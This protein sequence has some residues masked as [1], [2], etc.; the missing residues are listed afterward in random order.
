MQPA[1]E[2]IPL[3]NL[4]SSEWSIR[5][6]F[7]SNEQ[8][9]D[10]VNN[11]PSQTELPRFV[12]SRLSHDFGNCLPKYSCTRHITNTHS[13]TRL[14]KRN[15]LEYWLPI[16][17]ELVSDTPYWL[18]FFLLEFW[19]LCV[20]EHG[21]QKT[22]FGSWFLPT[23]LLNEDLSCFCCCAVYSRLAGLRIS[24]PSSCLCLYSHLWNAGIIDVRFLYGF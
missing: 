15:T 24:G 21:D 19:C 11:I 7:V 23:T 18:V 1:R 13:I 8:L 6:M 5:F 9:W 2:G 20:Y 4:I 17:E 14:R 16:Q 22:T 10:F 3:D 12:F